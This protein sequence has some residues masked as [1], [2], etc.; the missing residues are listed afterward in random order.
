MWVLRFLNG[1]LTGQ[2]I[3]LREGS[4]TLGRSP[5]CNIPLSHP[6]VS[7]KH[8]IL[9]VSD[10]GIVLE[11]L[12][13][14]NGCFINGLKVK[15]Q[16][17]KPTDKI[18]FFDVMAEI[19]NVA[20]ISSAPQKYSF[21]SMNQFGNLALKNQNQY[22]A[23]HQHQHIPN[24]SQTEPH[25]QSNF[26]SEMP[27]QEFIPK[28]WQG[29]LQVVQNYV[30]DVILPGIYKLTEWAEFKWILLMFM[31]LFIVF[32]TSLSSI[33]LMSILKSSIESESQR[34]ALT[35]A[36]TLAKVNQ[37]ELMNGREANVSTEL[38]NR[39]PG[40]NRSYIFS[41]ID[42]MIIS[43]ASLSGKYPPDKFVH[44]A[45]KEG[46]EIV[47]QLDSNT[48]G[49]LVP[50]EFYN[51]QTG[52]QSVMAF[53]VVLYDMGSLAVDDGK[54]LSLFI[55]TFFIAVIV[56]SILFFFLYK[57]VE[58][59]YKNINK[60]LDQLLKEGG[61]Q[62]HLNYQFP[63]VQDLISNIGSAL[64]R[65]GQNSESGVENFEVDRSQEM[66][67]LVQLVGFPAMAIL[68]E[69]KTVS[70]VNESFLEKVGLQSH[71]ILYGSIQ[72][73]SDQSLK[74]SLEDLVGRIHN[75]P[76]VMATNE[77]EFSGVQHEIM[78]LPIMGHKKVAYI[79]IV[80][81]PAEGA[82]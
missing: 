72:N 25:N 81:L 59:P 60:Q 43:P 64:S 18:S 42:N 41:N 38:A 30:D 57:L 46:R 47:T 3:N 27:Q 20:D 16:K 50:I 58:Y 26:R 6:G 75:Q 77:L 63:V 28:G 52:T 12:G 23:H 11:D 36:R 78:A 31:G 69:D 5:D 34:R 1:P 17:I 54:T 40:V 82:T 33:P 55:Q 7:K 51:P 71:D 61:Q 2:L 45:R 24:I 4:N 48:I 56:G 68:P 19:I 73:I 14:S 79:L 15:K 53:A 76:E 70:A 67:Q 80:I 35:I 49:A 32:V 44:S 29:F 65:V 37:V 13:S 21:P 9:H 10:T 66:G 62:I 39:E 74:L 8:C 22:Q